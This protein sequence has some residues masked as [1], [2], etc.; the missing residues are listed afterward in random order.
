M[1]KQPLVQPGPGTP[2]AA[3]EQPVSLSGEQN[4]ILASLE[5]ALAFGDAQVKAALDAN[6]PRK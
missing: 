3:D 1:A 2:T 5:Q 4:P 6:A